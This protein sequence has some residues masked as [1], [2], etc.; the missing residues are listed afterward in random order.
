[1]LKTIRIIAL[2]LWFIISILL[3]LMISIFRP[4]NPDNLWMFSILISNKKGVSRDNLIETLQKKGIQS[5]PFFYPLH[6]YKRF[7]VKDNLPVAEYLGN[8]GI[9]LPSGPK[10]SKEEIRFV[11][12]EISGFLS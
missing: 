5:R 12:D 11:C 2:I 3:I 10:I 6:K 7:N 8:C 1:M 4:S 9:S